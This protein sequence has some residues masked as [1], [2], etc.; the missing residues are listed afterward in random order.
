[1]VKTTRKNE[2]NKSNAQFAKGPDDTALT[3]LNALA[4]GILSKEV[5]IVHGKGQES[6]VEFEELKS[7]MVTDLAPAGDT[8]MLAVGGLGADRPSQALG[9]LGAV[10]GPARAVE[11][12]PAPGAV[13]VAQ[14]ASTPGDVAQRE[15]R[16]GECRQLPLLL[17]INHIVI[18]RPRRWHRPG[19]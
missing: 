12:I 18:G 3:R 7:A 9:Q 19:R 14:D 17:D 11:P 1:M 10:I 16:V 6:I 13:D 2:A 5:V 15:G 8:L 4:H